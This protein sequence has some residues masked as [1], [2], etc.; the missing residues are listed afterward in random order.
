MYRFAV[1]YIHKSPVSFLN[2]FYIHLTEIIVSFLQ[3][4]HSCEYSRIKCLWIKDDLQYC[5]IIMYAPK[6]FMQYSLFTAFIF[7]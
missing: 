3:M 2:L 6:K 5:I 4:D 1:F 7:F